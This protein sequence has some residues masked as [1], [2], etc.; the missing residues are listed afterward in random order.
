MWPCYGYNFSCQ[1]ESPMIVFKYY[2]IG[3][4]KADFS[5]TTLPQDIS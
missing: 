3:V 2:D 1:K 5:N 4:E